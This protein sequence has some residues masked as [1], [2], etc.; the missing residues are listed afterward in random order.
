[1]GKSNVRVTVGTV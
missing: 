1:M